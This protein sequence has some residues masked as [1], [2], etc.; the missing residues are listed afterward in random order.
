MA[1]R[2]AGRDSATRSSTRCATSSACKRQR[3]I[4]TSG[5]CKP[6]LLILGWY[7]WI[8]VSFDRFNATGDRGRA[9]LPDQISGSVEEANRGGTC[10]PV[11]LDLDILRNSLCPCP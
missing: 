5:S 8:V 4:R 9:A 1:T 6:R 11:V 2:A 7:Q 3:T 10:E